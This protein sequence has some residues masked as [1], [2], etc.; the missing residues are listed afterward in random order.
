MRSVLLIGIQSFLLPLRYYKSVTRDLDKARKCLQKTF[1]LDPDC[2]EAGEALSDVY[3]Q[4]V[5]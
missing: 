3:R 1:K 4:Q 2:A 5:R